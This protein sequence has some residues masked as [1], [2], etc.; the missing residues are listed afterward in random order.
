MGLDGKRKHGE[1]VEAG[2]NTGHPE[3]D[4]FIEGKIG[5]GF[6]STIE[7]QPNL[8]EYARE[9]EAGPD[10]R[11]KVKNVRERTPGPVED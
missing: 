1:R 10:T 5:S 8:D 6:M 4:Q 7:G 2:G 3:R 9:L 11:N